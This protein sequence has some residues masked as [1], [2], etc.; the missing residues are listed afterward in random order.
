M[1]GCACTEE[2]VVPG[3][4]VHDARAVLRSRHCRA[5]DHAK[6]P[7]WTIVSGVPGP[8]SVGEW[9]GCLCGCRG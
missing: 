7:G 9:C 3:C 8:M 6:C 1:T 5:G 2:A 4:A